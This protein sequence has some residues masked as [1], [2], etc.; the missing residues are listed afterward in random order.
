MKV[1]ILAAGYAMRLY[2]LT[3][4]QPKP[5]LPVAGKP[6]ID[7]VMDNL[8]PGETS[9]P[10]ATTAKTGCA[11]GSRASMA[12]RTA[13]GSGTHRSYYLPTMDSMRCRSK[14]RGRLVDQ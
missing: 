1:F 13:C 9:V 4:T 10:T 14:R 11:G 8:G 7:Y 2:P 6:M 5:L 3:L 12:A